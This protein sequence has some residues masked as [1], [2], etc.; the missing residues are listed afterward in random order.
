MEFNLLFLTRT[1]VSII[2]ATGWFLI[3]LVYSN[4]SKSKLTKYFILMTVLMF[5][6]VDFAW[7]AR[8]PGQAD[9]ALLW[10]RIAWSISPFL[11][12]C[13]YYFS[14]KF[15]QLDKKY[16][17]LNYLLLFIGIVLFFIILFTNFIIKDIRFNEYGIL[18][19]I[20]GELILYFFGSVFF[21]SILSFW[22]F[23]RE[24]FRAK[25]TEEKK[26]IKFLLAG[27]FFFLLMNSIFNIYCPY[28]LKIFHLYFLGDYSTIVFLSTITIT[29]VRHKLFNIKIFAIELLTY[30]I[31][32]VFSLDLFQALTW[33][34][35]FFKLIL[36]TLS[37]IFGLLLIRSVKK[38]IKQREILEKLTKQLEK[39]NEKLK[40]LDAAKSEFI[41]IASHQLRTPLT[42]IKGYISMLMLG[43]FGPIAEKEKEPL[44]KIYESSE[45]LIQLVENLLNVS[46]IESGRL[47]FNFKVM[48]LEYL[49]LSVMEELDKKA[50][51]KGLGLV[52]LKPKKL[53]SEI[54]FDEE[55]LRQ[56]VVNLID[57]SIK[58]TA[59][60][61]VEVGL[62]QSARAIEFSV[63][64]TGAGIK[65]DDL[66]KLFQKFSRGTGKTAAMEGTGLGL[67]VARQMVEAHKGKIWAESKGEGMGSRFCFS[68]PV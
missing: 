66:P 53:L 45:R 20:Y 60:G 27:L 37:L 7:L 46:R 47:Q 23:F 50:K 52:Y 64:D 65:K 57:N 41:S 14:S 48:Q 36:F 43:D 12:V 59:K 10:I 25:D 21:L 2:N 22:A 58:Y 17:F 42:V 67:Y 44:E 31:W 6:W 39:A 18:Q 33:R 63:S 24:L 30:T 1:I 55:K 29:I 4:D 54:K 3:F 32:I 38:E 49:V 62:K 11:F 9:R 16:R 56:V 61:K 40:K 34:D 5:V 51:D 68:L 15:T 13:I 35:R 8:I 19:I 26:K 28:F